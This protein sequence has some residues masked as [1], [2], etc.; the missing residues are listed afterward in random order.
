M[1]TLATPVPDQELLHRHVQGDS[2]DAFAELVRRHANLVH[3]AALRQVNGDA[4]EAMEV[5]QE[6]FIELSR[7]AARIARHPAPVGWLYTTTRRMALRRIRDRRRR[8]EQDH[9]AHG[10]HTLGS[11]SEPAVEWERLEPFLDEAMHELRESDRLAI[12]WR[13][14][15]RRSFPEIGARLGL[16]ENGARMRVERALGKLRARLKRRGI[17]SPAS[18]IT[19]ALEGSAVT[20]APAGL[21]PLVGSLALPPVIVAAPVP[22][23]FTLMNS[24]ALKMGATTVVIGLVGTGLWIQSDRLERL[25]S[26]T[27]ALRQLLAE[28]DARRISAEARLREPSAG[29]NERDALQQELL[30]LRGELARLRRETAASSQKPSPPPPP[31]AASP[32][33]LPAP[34]HTILP[35]GHSLVTGGLDWTEGR[36]AVLIVTPTHHLGNDGQ[37]QVDVE[38]RILLMTDA[39]MDEFGFQN[40]GMSSDDGS[41]HRSL[42]DAERAELFSRVENR[43]DIGIMGNT[44]LTT[45]SGRQ[46]AVGMVSDDLPDVMVVD[47]VPTVI[48]DGQVNMELVFRTEPKPPENAS[49]P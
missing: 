32:R 48:T 5:A 31:A 38:S 29:D 6:V 8:E 15:E 12:L 18:A 39:V 2:G 36:R 33:P 41:S 25:R 45:I 22:G 19:V 47:I 30:R 35:A 4:S 43:P 42:T 46:G 23:L 49:P 13:Y 28:S 27:E 9:E 1:T 3:A 17:T 37:A 40:L 44:H 34:V 14:F 26:E 24:T 10:M 21:A 7:K 20:A 16:G 11:D